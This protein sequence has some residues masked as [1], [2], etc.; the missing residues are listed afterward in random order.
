MTTTY[1]IGHR[2][3]GLRARAVAPTTGDPVEPVQLVGRLIGT[4]AQ[5]VLCWVHLETEA[6]QWEELKRSTLLVN[7]RVRLTV[8]EVRE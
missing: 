5:G 6:G 1:N 2:S 8:E 7:R 3:F 4:E